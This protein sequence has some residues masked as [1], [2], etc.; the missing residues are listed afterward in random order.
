MRANRS[1]A[2]CRR[3]PWRRE[4]VAHEVE[5]EVVGGPAHPDAVGGVHR[6][7]H[8]ERRHR[9]LEPAAG[10]VERLTAEQVVLG[11]ADVVEGEARRLVA[12]RA[13]LVL[14]LE[15]LEARRVPLDDERAVAVAAEGRIDRRPHDHPLGARRVR[16]EHLLSGEHPLVALLAGAGLDPGDVTAGARLGHRHRPPAGLRVVGE[17][18]AGSAP[19][20]RAWRSCAAPSRRDRGRAATGPRRGPSRRSPRRRGSCAPASSPAPSGLPRRRSAAR[21]CRP[22]GCR[23]GRTRGRPAAACAVRSASRPIGLMWVRPRARTSSRSSWV[24]G[25]SSITPAVPAS[26]SSTSST[27]AA[28]SSSAASRAPAS[29]VSMRASRKRFSA[30]WSTMKPWPPRSWMPRLVARWAASTASSQACVAQNGGV[31]FL[32]VDRRGRVAHRQ[33][34]AVHAGRGVG[35]VERVALV[36]GDRLAEHHPLGRVADR[37][38]Q[39]RA[40]HADRDGRRPQ[41]GAA[42]DGERGPRRQVPAAPLDGV[43]QRE[44]RRHPTPGRRAPSPAR[45]GRRPRAG[46]ACRPPSPTPTAAPASRAPT[47]AAPCARSGSTT[48]NAQWADPSRQAAATSAATPRSGHAT[49]APAAMPGRSAAASP[50]ASA[51]ASASRTTT[52]ASSPAPTPPSASGRSS[53][54][55]GNPSST[56]ST[57]AGQR[58][59][60]SCSRTL[61]AS[62]AAAEPFGRRTELLQLGRELE[63]THRAHPSGGPR[64]RFSGDFVAFSATNAAK[65]PG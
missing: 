15:D 14:D 16:A 45:L 59:A 60:A 53:P 30:R 32:A 18:A 58:P 38:V 2:R 8:V 26:G 61:G 65:N 10:L 4:L 22:G 29:I 36:V 39:R 12:A 40:G 25:S 52:L 42:A 3:G 37:V 1:S 64:V 28:T 11:D 7:G 13:H 33:P 9:R 48:V 57:A 46:A 19:A 50:P 24:R 35:E 21:R 31:G 49:T 56:A 41:P 17:H 23:A 27:N 55:S 62:S 20:A 6:A 47:P 51:A 63:A 43:G 34:G 54:P 44:R 5:R